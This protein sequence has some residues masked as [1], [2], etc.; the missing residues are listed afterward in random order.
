MAMDN[1]TIGCVALA[2]LSALVVSFLMTPVVK[3]FAYKVG[4]VD[5]PKDSRRMHKV[6]TPRLRGLAIFMGF[7]VSIL[8]FVDITREMRSILLGAVI[9]AVCGH[10]PGDAQYSAGGG[11]HRGAGCGG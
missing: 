10:H 9:T 5:V 3:T 11:H 8:L 6:P 7:M 1:R 4:A 2:L